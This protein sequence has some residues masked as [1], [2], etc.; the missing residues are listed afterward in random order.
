MAD[1]LSDA[2]RPDLRQPGNHGAH[3]QGKPVS[4]GQA[5]IAFRKNACF[6]LSGKSVYRH[7][8][9]FLTQNA[10]LFVD[11]FCVSM[12]YTMCGSILGI[13]FS[14][15]SF[16]QMHDKGFVTNHTWVD[17]YEFDRTKSGYVSKARAV[18]SGPFQYMNRRFSK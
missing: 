1:G 18:Y 4:S 14:T 5:V 17:I 6:A 9:V 15:H 16:N 8:V 10:L 7:N 3:P 13:E 11:I 12:R 2:L